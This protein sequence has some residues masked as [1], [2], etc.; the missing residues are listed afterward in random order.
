VRGP[1]R[2]LL[3]DCGAPPG[4][5]NFAAGLIYLSLLLNDRGMMGDGVIEL[6]KCRGWIED[7]GY[8]GFP[9]VEIFSGYWWQKPGEAVLD[10]CIER[11]M[12]VG[13]AWTREKDHD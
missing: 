2:V 7:A 6:K 8:S 5:S 10:T 3:P 13:W 4:H 12:S 11:H 9:E 1:G